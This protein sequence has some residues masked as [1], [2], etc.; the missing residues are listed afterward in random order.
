MS[1]KRRRMTQTVNR[2]FEDIRNQPGEPMQS[3]LDVVSKDLAETLGVPRISIWRFD[4][5]FDQM[6]LVHENDQDLK[7][8]IP[9]ASLPLQKFPNFAATLQEGKPFST[10]QVSKDQAFSELLHPYWRTHDIRAALILPLRWERTVRAAVICED[11]R[12]RRAW[13]TGDLEKAKQ[14]ADRLIQPMQALDLNRT[15]QIVDT[16]R[17]IQTAFTNPTSPAEAL[18]FILERGCRLTQSN[19]GMAFLWLGQGMLRCVAQHETRMDWIG[20]IHRDKTDPVVASAMD[21]QP[22][23]IADANEIITRDNLSSDARRIFQG[24]QISSVICLPV[25]WQGQTAGTLMFLRR[26]NQTPFAMEDLEVIDPLAALAGASIHA[27]R[28]QREASRAEAVHDA[29]Q[30]IGDIGDAAISIPDLL[31]SS[32][33]QGCRALEV[34]M[35]VVSLEDQQA[36]M[37][38]SQRK[39]RSLVSLIHESAIDLTELRAIADW[40]SPPPEAEPLAEEITRSG[41]RSSLAAPLQNGMQQ[42]GVLMFCSA[43]PRLWHKEEISMVEIAA[44]LIGASIERM[45]ATEAVQEE[46]ALMRLLETTS[47]QLNQARGYNSTLGLVGDGVMTL[48]KTYRAAVYMRQPDGTPFISWMSGLTRD[49]AEDVI[50]QKPAAFNRFFELPAHILVSRDSVTPGKTALYNLLHAGAFPAVGLWPMV[51]DEKTY[52]VVACYYDG[53]P[54]LKILE[55]EVLQIF[56]RQA[57]AALV[58]AEL[59]DRLEN[60]YVQTA[61]SL[62]TAVEDSEIDPVER[63]QRLADLAHATARLMG[64]ADEDLEAIYWA[65]LLHDVGKAQVPKK[66]L[67]KTSPLEPQEWEVLHHVPIA[68]ER[69]LG[70]A[71]AFRDA[72]RLV[73]H[74][75]EHFDG[76]GY[77]D[78]LKG[79]Q[80]PLGARILAVADAFQAMTEKRPY[81]DPRSPEEAVAELSR[82]AGKQFDPVVVDSFI[83]A[84]HN[85]AKGDNLLH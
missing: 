2:G 10:R 64:L 60:R 72:A 23:L 30:K 66:V 16:I 55:R 56:L 68:G 58:N 69:L 46:Y 44:D 18:Q 81:H 77:P 37:G 70:E 26:E 45:E 27:H 42:R 28:F 61:L 73:R 80:I 22:R 20:E 1:E 35:G 71:T 14:I 67:Q 33:E 62:A 32:L 54:H 57:T 85:Q 43:E 65:A 25:R 5:G 63:S 7:D 12:A 48:G 9:K 17:E 6:R 8:P 53:M 41:I 50:G 51:Y 47:D 49:Y 34:D 11:R 75:R 52:A 36:V 31:S 4:R 79:E 21:N 3:A 84:A 83:Q 39:G 78:R 24:E 59:Y 38:F 15:N 19:A 82:Q 29:L 74:F 13:K 76:S 40:Q